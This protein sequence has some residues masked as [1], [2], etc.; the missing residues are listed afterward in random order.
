MSSQYDWIINF[1]L[2][3]K[4]DY[5]HA[6]IVTLFIWVF[7]IIFTSS[8]KSKTMFQAK[9]VFLIYLPVFNKIELIVMKI[10]DIECW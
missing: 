9:Y 4:W 8:H 2:L 6:V 7:Y 10:S 3:K 5:E 1:I